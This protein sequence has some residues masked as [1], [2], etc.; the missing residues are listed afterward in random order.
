MKRNYNLLATMLVISLVC[1]FVFAGCGGNSSESDA[2]NSSPVKSDAGSSSPAETTAAETA[3][4]A[5]ITEDP[6]A[7]KT[8]EIVSKLVP[9]D[10]QEV[11][12]DDERAFIYNSAQP[13][14]DVAAYIESK[15][16]ELGFSDETPKEFIDY[17]AGWVAIG[18]IDGLRLGLMVTALSDGSGSEITI[19]FESPEQAEPSEQDTE[20]TEEA[21]TEEA[22]SLPW[23]DNDYTKLF[24]NPGF[25]IL[26][27]ESHERGMVIEFSDWSI[28][29][30]KKYA[31]RLQSDY[32]FTADSAATNEG[33]YN[34]DSRNNDGQ[35]LKFYVDPDGTG[36]FRFNN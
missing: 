23:P 7:L 6:E 27:E 3:T 22:E 13:V 30:A 31:K 1:S 8:K 36:V 25:K 32:G 21:N 14:D 15:L 12:S 29:D 28:K 35:G 24:P 4:A 26:T 33:T 19:G 11:G 20:E 5:A 16:A 9:Q 17:S 10:A 18:L 2:G 34:F